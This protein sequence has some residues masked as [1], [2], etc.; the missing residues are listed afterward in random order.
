MSRISSFAVALS[1]VLAP[2][3]WAQ[4][5]P[6]SGTTGG[7]TTNTAPP[8]GTTSPGNTQP[9]RSTDPFDG[10]SQQPDPRTDFQSPLILSGKVLLDDGVPPGESVAVSTVCDGQRVP[11]GY[12]NSKGN[13]TIDLTSSHN[14]AFADASVSGSGGTFG[15][16]GGGFGTSGPFGSDLASRSS[17]LGRVNLFGCELVAELAGY[18]SEGVQ[19]GTRS[20]FDNPDIGTIVMR[21]LDGVAGA[22][23]SM[24][25]LTAPKKA[26]KAFR[27]AVKEMRKK[28]PKHEKALK[29]LEKSVAE[30]PE[31]AAAWN[32]MGLVQ[33]QMQDAPAAR[34]AFEKA[35]EADEKYLSPYLPLIKMSLQEQR[36]DEVSRMTGQLLRLNPHVSEAY[37]YNAIANFNAGRLEE[38]EKAIADLR[39]RDDADKIPGSHHLLGMIF[40][41]RGQFEQAAAAFRGYMAVEPDS[42][43]ASK[44]KRQVYEW[45]QLGVVQSAAATASAGPR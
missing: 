29:E 39:L 34:E 21:R 12:T 14:M 40:V 44:L 6:D 35:V 1:L 28:K 33:L 38:A 17:G 42:Q 26:K 4:Q 41:K 24:T 18:R 11:R 31:Y 27:K 20:V 9:G 30:H 13:F 32:M 43:L 19:L 16:P 23:I 37:F 10:R 45:E 36:W 3:V 8:A 22:S 7:G 5:R 15:N 25:S 2:V